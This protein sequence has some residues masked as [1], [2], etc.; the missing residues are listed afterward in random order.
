MGVLSPK[1]EAHVL[2][3]QA[4]LIELEFRNVGLI[5]T[6]I[7]IIINTTIIRSTNKT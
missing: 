1:P 7:I 6:I 5:I 2:N 3:I 4:F